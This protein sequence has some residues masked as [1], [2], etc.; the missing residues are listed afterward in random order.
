M[1]NEFLKI[2]QILRD[3]VSIIA[4]TGFKG[5][6]KDTIGEYLVEYFGYTRF[7][8]GDPI[9]DA[10]KAIFSFNDVQLHGFKEKEIIDEYWGH[11][12]R[13]L[14]QMIGTELFRTKLPELCKNMT[15]N[16]WVK[17]L[18]KKMY[19]FYI[20]NP[21]INNK[22]V[23]TDV[24]FQNEFDAMKDLAGTIIRV[25][26]KIETNEIN[27]FSNHASEILINTFK[28]DY[29]IDNSYNLSSLHNKIEQI[30]NKV[31]TIN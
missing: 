3:N 1:E 31:D 2:A 9:K 15:S 21:K 29:E 28:V 22:F 4:L 11:A 6:G 30:I 5:S 13:E 26:R 7:A 18:I 24:R 17:S 19:E 8:F 14:F 20:L 27:Q 12:P 16:I 25:S 10:C 23:I